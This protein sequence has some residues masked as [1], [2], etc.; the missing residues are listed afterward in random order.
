MVVDAG[1]L[2]DFGGICWT[3]AG[4]FYVGDWMNFLQFVNEL[5]AISGLFLNILFF[6]KQFQ[7]NWIIL[8]NEYKILLYK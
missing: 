4:Y 2:S 7:M 1:K 5:S 8:T 6:K 3:F